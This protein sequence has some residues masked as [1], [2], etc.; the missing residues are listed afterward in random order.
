[1]IIT[2]IPNDEIESPWSLHTNMGVGDIVRIKDNT[3]VWPTFQ[4]AFKALWGKKSD[5]FHN[6]CGQM[7]VDYNEGLYGNIWTIVNIACH[8]WY[9]AIIL[10]HLKDFSGR[11]ILVGL[12]GLELVKRRSK[13]DCDV[14][15]IKQMPK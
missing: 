12:N 13:S 7:L 5:D 15:T 14:I 1:M 11:N 4:N 6:I 2:V 10:C 8:P 9:D 3:Y